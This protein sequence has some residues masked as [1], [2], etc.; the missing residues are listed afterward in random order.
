MKPAKTIYAAD[1]QPFPF[2]V[3]KTSLT[4]ELGEGVTRVSATLAI[5]RSDGSAGYSITLQGVG[6]RLVRLAI[7]GR[8]LGGGEY[9]LDEE[10]LV[11]HAVPASF[12]L[13]SVVEIHPESNTSLEGLYRSRG[14]FCTQCEAEGFRKITFF[15]DRP[16]VLSIFDTIIIAKAGDFPAMLSNGNCVSDDIIEGNRV[17][18]WHDPFPKPSYLFALVAGN[19]EYVEDFF[20]T[21][22]GRRVTIRIYVEKKDLGK[23]DHAMESLKHAMRWDE[24]VYGRE[25]DLD[26]FMIVAVDDF[27]MGAMEN[28]GLN[29]FNTSC[30]LA[31]PS[32]TTD[33]GFE[34]IE[35]IVAHEYFHNWS[36]NRV[37]CRDWFQL[38]L[39][40]G[41]TVYRDAEFSADRN[42]RAVKR[43][44]TANFLRTI[45]FAE[46]ASPLAHPVRP[47]SYMEISNFYT[48]T[49]YEKGAE[50]VRMLA[51]LLGPQLFRKGTDLY[52]SRH[53]GQAV[54]CEDFVRCME[55]V[56]GMDLQ[57]F[58]R[59]YSQAGTP[60]LT[61][62]GSYDVANRQYRLRV[63]QHTPATPGQPQKLP[64]HIPLKVALYGKEP[65]ERMLHLRE[66]EEVF[67]F[68]AVNE[69]PVPSLL[70][71]FS[72]PVRLDYPYSAKELAHLIVVDSDGFSRW[73][74]CYTLATRIILSGVARQRDVDA[75]EL[76]IE[77]YG[78][79][80]SDP[81]QDPAIVA[82]MLTLPEYAYL[83]DLLPVVDPHAVIAAI[84]E[85]RRGISDSLSVPLLAVRD[86]LALAVQ[87]RSSRGAAA[88]SLRNI[89]LHYLMA[90][91]D[92]ATES[93][94][95]E[96][97]SQAH[98]M[99]DQL[100][101][102]KMLV[103][104]PHAASLATRAL[105]EFHDQ[106]QSE[107][108]VM[109][110]WL[111]VQS[112]SPQPETA[113]RVRELLHHPVF[114]YTNPNKVRALIG[115][116]A[117]QNPFCFHMADGSGY[118][119][120]AEQVRY[121]DKLN[122]QIAARLVIPLTHWKKLEPVRSGL[123]R[124]ALQ[125]LARH[126]LSRDLYEVVHKGV[127]I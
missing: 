64:F 113:P 50:V 76:L 122:P 16:D 5:T 68:D 120:L 85:L 91:S 45:Q 126:E 11:I 124:E 89:A 13:E 49:I 99:T 81:A 127:S 75:T 14:M 47:D 87:D 65:H 43:V 17:V 34:R 115:S 88:R 90:R 21:Q 18:S 7:D 118:H 48:V 106:W 12:V 23:C 1:Y 56:S 116:F 55:E 73:N 84:E 110:L 98:T 123:M 28:K 39:K 42:S 27:N 108:L 22:S 40:E 103:N 72:A 3:S 15:P 35:A 9:N 51:N 94:C 25:Y 6:L 36:G 77:A 82:Q 69:A 93:A 92:M 109:N 105:Q 8:T 121:L 52:F 59:W 30:V 20:V 31:D 119:F 107:S 58:R 29:I 4:F 83:S 70:R 100:A 62:T 96:Q 32:I 95:Y 97:F 86:R 61:V 102:L 44:E 24:E 46:D 26:I 66:E 114:D 79:L 78:R 101:A 63:R 37:T 33:K 41:F 112:S 10:E 117:G 67:V 104:S 74:A 111:Q 2:R 38:S 19:L 57:Q 53:D 71:D 54:T 125:E 80:L 60:Q